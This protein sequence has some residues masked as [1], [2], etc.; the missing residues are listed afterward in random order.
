[1]IKARPIK[2]KVIVP[3]KKTTKTYKPRSNLNVKSRPQKFTTIAKYSTKPTPKKTIKAK[4]VK[5]KPVAKK[6]T[7]SSSSS[8][9]NIPNISGKIGQKMEFGPV[10][11]STSALASCPAKCV[12]TFSGRGGT[13]IKATFFKARFGSQLAKKGGKATISGLVT[14]GNRFLL[15]N[16]N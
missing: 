9:G 10:S 1:M 13:S 5:A 2:K 12:L 6:R 3:P 11:Y 4:P 7:S 14:A 15:Q 8:L 16:V